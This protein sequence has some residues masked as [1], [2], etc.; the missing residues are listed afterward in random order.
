MCPMLDVNCEPPPPHRPV[1][2]HSSGPQRQAVPICVIW[3][4]ISVVLDGRR[5]LWSSH[6]RD[7]YA[8]V[9]WLSMSRM[10]QLPCRFVQSTHCQ[11]PKDARPGNLSCHL[12]KWVLIEG[13]FC[14]AIFNSCHWPMMPV[15]WRNPTRVGITNTETRLRHWMLIRWW[16]HAKHSDHI[17][18][19]DQYC[20]NNELSLQY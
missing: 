9:S 1:I 5:C 13:D 20:T 8:D 4:V 12:L 19:V 11:H 10:R 14:E 15:R 2:D 7:R 6:R 17:R 18:F 16:S 3:T